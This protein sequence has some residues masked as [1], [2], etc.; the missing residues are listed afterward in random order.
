VPGDY[1]NNNRYAI[2]S[3]L[4]STLATNTVTSYRNILTQRYGFSSRRDFDFMWILDS[5]KHPENAPMQAAFTLFKQTIEA[6]SE[7]E[8]LEPIK[9]KLQPAIAYFDSLKVRITGTEKGDKKLRY[10]AY[11]FLMKM[12]ILLDNPDAAIKE[13]DLLI[14]NDYDDSDGKTYKRLAESLKA[15]LEKNNV[16]SRHFV[17]DVSGYKAPTSN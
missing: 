16:T 15:S 11:Y 2:R 7:E 10:A 13:A 1:Y 9:V 12:Y 6:M 3:G 4:A 17:I 14:A 8:D 5:K